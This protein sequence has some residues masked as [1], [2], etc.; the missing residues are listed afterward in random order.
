MDM[1]LTLHQARVIGCLLEKESTTPEYYPLSLNALTSACN[2][3]SNREPVLSLTGADVQAVLA[4]LV[5]E[6]LVSVED[7]GRVTRY[8]HRFCNTE[9]SPLQFSAQERAIICV[10][11][12][13]G[14][15]TPGEL[16]S[17]SARLA[18]FADVTE[19]EQVLQT[20]VARGWLAQLPKVP[21]KR[22]CRYR[23]LLCDEPPVSESQAS[24]KGGDSGRIQ[25]LEHEITELRAEIAR[26][27]Q[28][29]AE[30]QGN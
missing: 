26:L 12:L 3:K 13:R 5:A 24:P 4:T 7:R 16:R 6:R 21:G 22:E 19:T 2:Q 23:T 20:M 17:R 25:A 9:F 10:L 1:N 28:A 8:R 14:A 27:N 15:Q 11:L 30:R 29:L 18:S